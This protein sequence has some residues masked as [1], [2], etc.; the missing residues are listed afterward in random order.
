MSDS[1]N[2]VQFNLK[3][4]H[5]ALMNDTGFETPVAIPGSVNLNLTPQGD[6]THFYADGVEYYTTAANNGYSGDYE[7]ALFPE[8][9]LKDVW[10][11]ELDSNGVLV[12][13]ATVAPKNFAL[14]FQIDGD[15]TNSYYVVYN[16]AAQRPAITSATNE[17]SKTPKT[18]SL[19]ITATPLSDGKVTA[20]TTSATNKEVKE[21][22]FKTVYTGTPSTKE[23]DTENGETG[24]SG[25]T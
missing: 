25:T 10:G 23:E 6:T 12:E 4:A 19:S 22:W 7:A 18:Q 9:M 8:Q 2:K 17:N 13:N 14:L 16:V 21:N 1:E 3:N 11:F 20:R 5:Y 24:G 15:K